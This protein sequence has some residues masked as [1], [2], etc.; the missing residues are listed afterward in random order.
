MEGGASFAGNIL[1]LWF[2]GLVP[3]R[4]VQLSRSGLT[5]IIYVND[6]PSYCK[7]EIDLLRQGPVT[8]K[9]MQILDWK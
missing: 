6:M 4:Q 9:Y 3:A 8:R 5:R 7:G 2:L 1:E